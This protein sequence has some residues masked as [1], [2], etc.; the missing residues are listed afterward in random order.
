MVS[1][2]NEWDELLKDEFQ[3]PY[4]L[5]L[6]RFLKHEYA[7]QVIYPDMYDIF[8]ALRSTSYSDVK[9]VILGQ[10]PYHGPGQAHGLCFSVRPGVPAP[11]SLV[12]IFKELHDDVGVPM[13]RTGCLTPWTEQGVLLLNTVLTVRQGQP[14]SHKGKGWEIFTDRVI[15][16]LDRSDAPMVFLLWGANAGAKAAM[17]RN[18]NHLVLRTVHPS[19]LSVHRGFFGCR[20]FSKTNDFLIKN[21]LSPID[22]SI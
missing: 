4:Y 22:W 1:L 20:H 3:K 6:R 7:T 5:E 18:P 9:A 2:N 14:N 8:N 21:G 15:E 16:L 17:L 10:D 12:N 11:P 19:P 13:P